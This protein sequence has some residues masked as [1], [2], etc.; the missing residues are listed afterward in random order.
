MYSIW[1]TGPG[2][3]VEHRECTAFGLRDLESVETKRI[4]SIWPIRLVKWRIYIKNK[5]Y[6]AALYVYVESHRAN[7]SCKSGER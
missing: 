3:V 4:E 6:L 2:K 7:G 1:P 5:Q